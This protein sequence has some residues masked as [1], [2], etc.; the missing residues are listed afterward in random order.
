MGSQ[1]RPQLNSYALYFKFLTVCFSPYP[2]DVYSIACGC[3]NEKV[4]SSTYTC[5]SAVAQ[6]LTFQIIAFSLILYQ[7]LL[8]FYR[9]L[10]ESFPETDFRVFDEDLVVVKE[11][12]ILLR[13]CFSR[14]IAW[15]L[16]L[17]AEFRHYSSNDLRFQI[18]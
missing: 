2:L 17:L 9:F 5:F 18:N 11:F 12:S 8:Q 15:I 4:L 6:Q 1:V 7:V 16:Y 3:K 13:L 10:C 14:F